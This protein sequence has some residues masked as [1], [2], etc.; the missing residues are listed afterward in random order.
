[1]L[2]QLLGRVKGTI[3][4]IIPGQDEVEDTRGT[5]GAVFSVGNLQSAATSVSLHFQNVGVVVSKTEM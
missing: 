3:K 4:E 2:K 1:M 5:R